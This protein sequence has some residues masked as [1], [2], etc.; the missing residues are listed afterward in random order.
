T[1]IYTRV[2]V[3][4]LSE[5]HAAIHPGARLPSD[6]LAGLCAALDASLAPDDQA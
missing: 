2:M 3:G 1:Q 6:Q 5:V 4:K